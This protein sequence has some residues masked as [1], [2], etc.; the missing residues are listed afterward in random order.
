VAIAVAFLAAV[1]AI[2]LVAHG[3]DRDGAPQLAPA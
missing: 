2:A 1:L 3:V